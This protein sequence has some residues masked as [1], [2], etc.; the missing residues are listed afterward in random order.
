MSKEQSI[1][2]AELVSKGWK[3]LPPLIGGVIGGPIPV[4]SPPPDS[5]RWNLQS[6]GVLTESPVATVPTNPTT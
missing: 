3:E 2:L 4:L 1:K 6:D 5:K